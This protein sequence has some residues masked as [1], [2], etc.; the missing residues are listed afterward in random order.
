MIAA[1]HSTGRS[2]ALLGVA[3]R[4]TAGI[5]VLLLLAHFLPIAPLQVALAHIPPALFLLVLIGYLLAHAAGAAKWRM[6]VNAAGAG[7]NYSTAVQCYFGGLFGTL[8]LPSILDRKSTRLNS[9]H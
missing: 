6:V 7:L 8:F 2:R 4:W 3:L 5:L 1:S 9:S